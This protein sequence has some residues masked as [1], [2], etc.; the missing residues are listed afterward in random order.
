VKTGVTLKALGEDLHE[1][2]RVGL[3]RVAMSM[4]TSKPMTEA[5]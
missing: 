3:A 1:P 4:R 2:R 5:R